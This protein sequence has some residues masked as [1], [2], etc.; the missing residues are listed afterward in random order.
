M[1]ARQVLYHPATTPGPSPN[2]CVALN[3]SSKSLLLFVSGLTKSVS[4]V[5]VPVPS[6]P[7]VL[8]FR[9]CWHE[10]ITVNQGKWLAGS[11]ALH[12]V[13][14]CHWLSCILSPLMINLEVTWSLCWELGSQHLPQA[15]TP[16]HKSYTCSTLPHGA[17]LRWTELPQGHCR[18]HLGK[19]GMCPSHPPLPASGSVISWGAPQCI[20]KVTQ[21]RMIKGNPRV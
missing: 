17:G 21:F 2:L 5:S 11:G 8:Q 12:A 6:R 13:L 15:L 1:N 20:R 14:F 3:K 16:R 7:G 4:P 10:A 18:Q 9:H 19:V